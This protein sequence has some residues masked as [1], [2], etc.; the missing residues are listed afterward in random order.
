MTVVAEGFAVFKTHFAAFALW[1]CFVHFHCI[2][3]NVF[4]APFAFGPATLS[5]CFPAASEVDLLPDFQN[6]LGPAHV[7]KTLEVQPRFV[8]ENTDYVSFRA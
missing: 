2:P 7:P 1:Y 3:R 5:L 6:R 4:S 8:P